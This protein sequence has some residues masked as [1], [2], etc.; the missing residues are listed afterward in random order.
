MLVKIITYSTKPT[1][2]KFSKTKTVF[3]K[4]MTKTF[5]F[6]QDQDHKNGMNINSLSL[7]AIFL[8]QPQQKKTGKISTVQ[9]IKRNN[10]RCQS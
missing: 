8:Q 10:V 5:D 6:F 7:E 4:T 1:P 3:V 2:C 9:Y